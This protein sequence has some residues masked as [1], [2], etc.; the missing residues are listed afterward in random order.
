MKFVLGILFLIEI[1]AFGNATKNLVIVGG[2]LEDD[3]EQI[4]GRI[5]D[6]A[7]GLS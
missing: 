1:F 7:V 2:N 6:L 5:I 3:N 4:Y